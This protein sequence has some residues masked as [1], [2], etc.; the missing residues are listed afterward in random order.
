VERAH[1]YLE[2]GADGLFVL[3]MTPDEVGLFAR[4]FAGVPQIYNMSVRGD[5]PK[6]SV[7]Q[8]SE[9]GYKLVIVPNLLSLA[10]A[11]TAWEA[12]GELR[13]TGSV[14]QFLDRIL[15]PERM[16]EIS[17]FTAADAYQKQHSLA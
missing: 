12:L 3:G 11:R 13:D 16:D 4:E 5:G 6:L 1:A 10:L 7:A 8:L 9:L 2:A 15:P 14:A 17:G